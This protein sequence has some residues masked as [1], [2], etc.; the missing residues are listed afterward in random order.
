MASRIAAIQRGVFSRD[1]LWSDNALL[2]YLALIV[3]VGHLLTSTNYGYQRDEFYY[4]TCGQHLAWGYV[5]HPPL[6]PVM[7]NVSVWLFGNTLFALRFFPALAG[8]LTVL[9]TGL[10]AR[11][12]G[13]N[14]FAQVA[15]A[16][17]TMMAPLFIAANGLLWPISVDILVW[18]FSSYLVLRIIKYREDW[19][20]ALA[21]LTVGVGLLNKYNVLFFAAALIGGLIAVGPRRIFRSGWFW[22]GSVLAFLVVLPNLLWQ[23]Q[24]GWPTFEFLQNLN[25][26]VMSRISRPQFLAWQVIILNPCGLPLWLAGLYFYLYTVEGKPYKVFAFIFLSILAFLLMVNGKPYYLGAA[27]PMLFAA[28]PVAIMKLVRDHRMRWTKVRNGYVALLSVGGLLAFPAVLPSLPADSSLRYELGRKWPTYAEILGWD[29]LV[30]QVAKVYKGLPANERDKAAILTENY[31]EA[32][33]LDVLGEHYALPRA[34]SGHNTYYLWGPGRFTGE[35]CITVGLSEETV[36]KMFAEVTLAD[37]IT[38]SQRIQ[39]LEF[40]RPIYICRKPRRPLPEMWPLL[41][42]FD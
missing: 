42:H 5:D 21:G 13:G 17:S 16:V 31:G 37:R 40:G 22:T 33:A 1:A 15:A 23:V 39:N 3:L 7:A 24:H 35:V 28:A 27:Y 10:T 36:H 20:W 12:L 38:N 9:I 41:K 8:A 14:R 4:V 19:L 29:E 34:I 6:T 30:D 25:R 26:D 32:G 18:T 11:E 2:I